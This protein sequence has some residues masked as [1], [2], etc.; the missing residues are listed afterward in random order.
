M[1]DAASSALGPVIEEAAE[2]GIIVVTF[3]NI[4]ETDSTYSIAVDGGKF[5]ENQARWLC[6][7]LGGKGNI[8]MIRGKAGAHDD[9]IRCEG[10]ERVL[11]EYPDIKVVG[12][13]YGE[14]DFGTTHS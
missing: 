7:T 14:W 2:Q 8:L 4:V 13:G 10:Y 6:E 12:D 9:T 1:V 5:G 3:D 11:K